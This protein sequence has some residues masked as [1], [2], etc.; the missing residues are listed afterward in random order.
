MYIHFSEIE[1]HL[2]SFI[3]EPSA[4]DGWAQ[5]IVERVKPALDKWGAEY[6]SGGR[7]LWDVLRVVSK[8][9]GVLKKDLSRENF[10]SLVCRVCPD[11]GDPK[12]L[13][14]SLK[15]SQAIHAQIQNYDQ[16]SENVWLKKYGTLI[17]ALFDEAEASGGDEHLES[18]PAEFLGSILQVRMGDDNKLSR[19][20]HNRIYS[21]GVEGSRSVQPM[22]SIESYLS[23][24]DRDEEKYSQ[25]MA[26]EWV[27]E[28]VTEEKMA[29]LLMLYRPFQLRGFKLVI[30]STHGFSGRVVKDAG[31]NGV[32]LCRL[33]PSVTSEEALDVVVRRTINN[34]E[35]E[36]RLKRAIMGGE[37]SGRM[38][39][40]S[41][42]KLTTLTDLMYHSG[43]EVS[44]RYLW[45][46]P[47]YTKEQ[48]EKI[49]DDV[50]R[51]IPQNDMKKIAMSLAK[52]YSDVSHDFIVDG[53]EELIRSLGL[54]IMMKE[55]PIDQYA[56]LDLVHKCIIFNT[57]LAKTSFRRAGTAIHIFRF[58]LAH[59]L[60]HFIL[61]V[62]ALEQHIE[63]FTETDAS[64]SATP[65]GDEKVKRME[66][67]ANYF[68]ACLLMPRK[69]VSYIFHK[70]ITMEDEQLLEANHILLE[71]QL[72]HEKLD[73]ILE[74]M[75][76][77]MNVSKK[78]ARIRLSELSLVAEPC[79][80][81][82]ERIVHLQ[83]YGKRLW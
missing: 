6:G 82:R 59:E 40:F 15:K 18:T 30:V 10:A 54:K 66:W 31:A 36:R 78:A 57:L 13:N 32:S 29:F 16:L 34:E 65:I 81:E 19:L 33:N 45:N 61:H 70:S 64:L 24:S 22:W 28:D 77:R 53:L 3:A 48:I 52:Q 75:S 35:T 51:F 83:D 72:G 9:R 56:C 67:Q 23:A 58:S 17:E 43:I 73:A 11:L 27:E 37:M 60:G 55:M 69:H 12:T 62:H 68:A 44:S 7:S 50:R 1:S 47:F 5:A 79:F 2:R 25:V 26:W 14:A 74:T 46:V 20:K 38:I 42:G 71:E 39:V 8:R 80:E 49:A 41:E 76:L 63:S 4:F 21:V